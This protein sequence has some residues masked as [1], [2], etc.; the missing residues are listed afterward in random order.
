MGVQRQPRRSCQY[1]PT[2]CFQML[3][4]V[5]AIK[6]SANGKRENSNV[7]WLRSMSK[8]AK[9]LKGRVPEKNQ[10]ELALW[11]SGE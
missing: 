1:S 11:V 8:K 6:L 3:A 9:R 7:H 10:A 5:Q 2:M 4:C